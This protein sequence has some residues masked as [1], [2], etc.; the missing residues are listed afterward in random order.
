MI[1]Y[2][3]RIGRHRSGLTQEQLAN[4]LGVSQAMVSIWE[5]GRRLPGPEFIDEI[6]GVLGIKLELEEAS[7]ISRS[8]DQVRWEGHWWRALWVDQILGM[9]LL[10]RLDGPILKYD[11]DDDELDLLDLSS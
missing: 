8:G 6:N 10:I 4:R 11:H 5:S 9:A 7:I 2:E 1:G 3:I